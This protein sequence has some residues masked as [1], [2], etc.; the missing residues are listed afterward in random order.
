MPIMLAIIFCHETVWLSFPE[1]GF[2]NCP[3][4]V[5]VY[6]QPYLQGDAS[7]AVFMVIYDYIAN[8]SHFQ[9]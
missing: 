8:R 6:F 2:D 1:G 5:S 3:D 9:S 7:M 4:T